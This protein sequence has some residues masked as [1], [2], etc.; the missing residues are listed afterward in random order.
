MLDN[1]PYCNVKNRSLNC[2]VSTYSNIDTLD[3]LFN[4]IFEIKDRVESIH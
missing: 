1:L 4:F 3:K 2:K